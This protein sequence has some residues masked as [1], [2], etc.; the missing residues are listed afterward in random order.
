V[1]VTGTAMVDIDV[2]G[3]S[4]AGG[5]NF[6]AFGLGNQVSSTT[7]GTA[8]TFLGFDEFRIS[9]GERFY[10]EGSDQLLM[11]PEPSTMAL[12]AL[13]GLMMLRRRKRA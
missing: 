11:F 4:P 8:S 7:A 1:E 12:L 6:H 13:G 9:S 3:P 10:L 2:S 5:A